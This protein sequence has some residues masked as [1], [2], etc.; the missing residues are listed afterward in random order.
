MALTGAGS[1]R[2]GAGLGVPAATVRGWLRRLRSAAEE[3]RQDAMHQPSCPGR[4][5]RRS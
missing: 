2:I 5:S 4:P 1:G 3:M